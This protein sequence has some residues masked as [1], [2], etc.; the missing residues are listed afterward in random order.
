MKAVVLEEHGPVEALQY[1]ENHLLSELRPHEVRVQVKY[2]GLNHLDLWLRRG[3]TGDHLQLPRIPGS[4]MAGVI[5]EVGSEVTQRKPGETVLI[6]PGIGCG[7]C[8]ACASGR[9]TLCH[10]FAVIGY[11]VDGGYAE[12]IHIPAVNAIPIP[13]EEMKRWAAVPVA[14]V[15]AWNALVTKAALAPNDTVAIWGATGGLGYAAV[16]I[17]EGFGAK[18]IAIVGSEE[19]AEFLR[20]QGFQGD[21]LIRSEHLEEEIRQLTDKKGV[22]VVL[23][24]VGSATFRQSLRMLARGGRLACCGV[25][26]GP[27]CETDLRY[28]FGKQLSIFGSW[29]GDRADLMEVITFLQRT[30]R[31]PYIDRE[32]PLASAREAQSYLEKGQHVGKI[33]LSI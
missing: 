12:S 20:D 29:M 33:V 10:R 32:F 22:D 6:Y 8:S 16:A 30:G 17:A 7:H 2:C 27:K 21:V 5:T 19:K 1:K 14:Y 4:D 18:V 31:L 9:E 26:T 3:G 28:I 13:K 24:H 25:T 15:T 23:D 11:H